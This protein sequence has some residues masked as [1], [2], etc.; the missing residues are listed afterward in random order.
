M[1]HPE[2]PSHGGDQEAPLPKCYVT[3]PLRKTPMAV[4]VPLKRPIPSY[5]TCF[6]EMKESLNISR[7]VPAALLK[8]RWA[9][10]RVVSQSR[11]RTL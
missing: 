9:A 2:D 5:F 6:A 4:P 1:V 7:S 3:S 8:R 10:N 11:I